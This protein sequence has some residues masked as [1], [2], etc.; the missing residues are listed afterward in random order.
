MST[1]A[2]VPPATKTVGPTTIGQERLSVSSGLQASSF[3]RPSSAMAQQDS[4]LGAAEAS[5][6][7]KGSLS[8]AWRKFRGPKAQTPRSTTSDPIRT[9]PS[10]SSG[11]ARLL[12]RSATPDMA[13]SC[14]SKI[15]T[16]QLPD[17]FA[18]KIGTCGLSCQG[19]RRG[20]TISPLLQDDFEF[21]PTHRNESNVQHTEPFTRYE[22]PRYSPMT[23]GMAPNGF[24]PHRPSLSELSNQALGTP[25]TASDAPASHSIPRFTTSTISH[26]YAMPKTRHQLPSSEVGEG[27]KANTVFL[28]G[29]VNSWEPSLQPALAEPTTVNVFA[30]PRRIDVNDDSDYKP[31]EYGHSSFQSARSAEPRVWTWPSSPIP[32]PSSGPFLQLQ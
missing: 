16:E 30:S 27:Q 6:T 2:I 11:I 10:S 19:Y 13:F 5:I 4:F 9:W 3:D 17:S 23:S 12:S 32:I 25:P 31:H 24:F 21:P 28:H 1:P 26:D 22:D 20:I 29:T 18:H 7:R 15:S 14:P 8:K